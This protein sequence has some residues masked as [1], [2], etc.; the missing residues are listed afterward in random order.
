MLSVGADRHIWRAVLRP[1]SRDPGQP[2][3]ALDVHDPAQ[4]RA[5]AST[6]T[7]S[8]DPSSAPTPFRSVAE[9]IVASAAADPARPVL[10]DAQS[11][12]SAGQL[13][14]RSRD[15]AAHLFARGL[16]AGD[17]AGVLIERSVDLVCATLALPLTTWGPVGLAQAGA[18]AKQAEIAATSRRFRAEK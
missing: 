15:W 16:A 18:V 6:L 2:I 7:A 4:R 11:T 17:V 14:Q 1:G 9:R 13:E 10:L 8:T 12:L 5:W 3:A